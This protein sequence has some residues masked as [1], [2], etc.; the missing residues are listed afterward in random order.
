MDELQAYHALKAAMDD[1]TPV[2]EATWKRLKGISRYRTYSKGQLLYQLGDLPS[3]FAFVAEGLVRCYVSDES[4]A[5]YNK[6]FF[7]EGQ[8]P[9]AMTALLKSEP[10]L[11]GFE[12][13][14]HSHIIEID[15]VAYRA[16]LH[17]CHDLKMFQI[18]YLERN[19]LLAKDSREIQLVQEQAGDR[20]D[21][22]IEQYP[23]LVKRLPQYHIAS[24]LGVTP[25]QLSRIRKSR[26]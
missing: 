8:F 19:W 9:G 15:F 7:C 1:Y 12:A 25:T 10:S 2:S 14:E 22:F 5:E 16:L 3:S 23:Q 13:L 24:H 6:N 21:R 11:M 4:G 17:E 20:Y 26:N 18:H